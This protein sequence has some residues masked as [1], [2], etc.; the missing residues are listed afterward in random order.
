MK[1]LEIFASHQMEGKESGKVTVFVRN[2][3]CS[4]KPRCKWCDVQNYKPVEM[5]INVIIKKIKSYKNIKHVTFTGG[6][7]NC[8]Q[9]NLH[10]IM[11][12]LKG[13]T[14]SI[15]TNGVIFVNPNLFET[16][17]CSP[18]KQCLCKKVLLS[19]KKYNN[20][21]FKFVIENKKSYDK[22]TLIIK[23]LKLPKER[24]FLMPEGR[25]KK[26]I[27]DKTKWLSALCVKDGFNVTTRIQ[28]LLY[29]KKKGI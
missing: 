25:D 16:V 26:T 20:V 27:V 4:A 3:F 14:F 10:K 11:K 29:G 19:Y 7:F 2:F 17:A 12:E 21:I 18:K 24:C 15:E 9:N 6:D 22:W 13:Y 28:Y 8:E 5:P 1:I 23:K